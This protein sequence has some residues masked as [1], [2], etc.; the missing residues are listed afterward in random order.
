MLVMAG[1]VLPTMHA[2]GEV[3]EAT[4]RSCA[5]VDDAPNDSC[6]ATDSDRDEQEDDCCS[7]SCKCL[8]CRAAVVPVMH[9][10][11]PTRVTFAPLTFAFAAPIP[12]LA[13][14]DSDSDL[15]HPPKS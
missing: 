5:L 7:D 10:T 8:C 2:R 9:R 4:Q 15:F 3:C 1:L 14:Q 6:C 13:P 11:T 12:T